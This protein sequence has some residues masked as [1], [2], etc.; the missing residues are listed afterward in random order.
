[1]NKSAWLYT[2][3]DIPDPTNEMVDKGF[4]RADALSLQRCFTCE[5]SKP[6]RTANTGE[7]LMLCIAHGQEVP[8]NGVCDEYQH[9][10]D[11]RDVA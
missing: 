4:R 5:W 7:I 11:V 9:A 1:M 2:D 3:T 6:Y 8:D 10:S